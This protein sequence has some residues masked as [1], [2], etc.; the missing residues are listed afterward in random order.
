MT[1]FRPCIDLHAGA[2]KQIIGGTLSTSSP[3]SV[4]TNFVIITSYLFPSGAFSQER[5]DEVLAALG[6]DKEKLVIDLKSIKSLEPYTSEFLIHAADNEGLQRGID[7]DLVRALRLL[8]VKSLSGGKVD[9]TIG[10]ALDCFGG[11]L[12]FEECVAWNRKQEAEERR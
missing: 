9:L 10:S 8:L 3:E 5:L 12:P 7:T 4:K 2:V 6:G 1:R 11:A